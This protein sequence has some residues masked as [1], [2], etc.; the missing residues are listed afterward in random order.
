MN[1]A[2]VRVKYNVES[3]K[4]KTTQQNKEQKLMDNIINGKADEHCSVED[5]VQTRM[6]H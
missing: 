4:D 2:R 6:L 1:S 5:K 3:L